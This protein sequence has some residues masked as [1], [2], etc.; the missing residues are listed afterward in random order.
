MIGVAKGQAVVS[1]RRHAAS[2]RSQL[3]EYRKTGTQ[4]RRI[5]SEEEAA[6][7]S[8]DWE[9]GKEITQPGVQFEA[10]GDRAFQLDLAHELVTDFNEFRRVYSLENDPALVEPSWAT[11][12]I[13]ALASP[14]LAWILLLIGG[15]ALW[16]ELQTPGVGVGGF[17]AAVCFLLFFWSR[18]SP[19]HGD[20]VGGDFVRRGRRLHLAGDVRRS[21]R[22]RLR[23]RRRPADHL[24][25]RAG[26]PNVYHSTERL[27]ACA[28]A[29]HDGDDPRGDDRRRRINRRAQSLSYRTRPC[30]IAWCSRRRTKLERQELAMR[31]SVADWIHLLGARGTAA[32]RL[33]PS[34]KARFDDELVDVI[35]RGEAIEAGAAVEVIEAMGSRVV[36]R[37]IRRT[38]RLASRRNELMDAT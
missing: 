17:A 15:A 18:Y 12:L 36:V 16:I 11:V 32:T 25:H 23:H 13:E 37:A 33:L 7:L 35:T 19:R 5:A 2:F 9:R 38:A 20:V 27:P 22:R 30:S 21:R 28:A 1:L 34:G 8:N 31:E 14:G 10:T 4:L 26:Q 24:L 6:S 3:Y 29:R